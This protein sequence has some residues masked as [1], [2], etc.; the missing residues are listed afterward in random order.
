M[1]WP[2]IAAGMVLGLIALGYLAL[3]SRNAHIWIGAYAVQ[4]LKRVPPE[5][6]KPVHLY[7]CLMDHFEPFTGGASRSKALERTKRWCEEFPR[8]A[9]GF[10]DFHGRHPKHVL[11]YPQE[12]YDSEIIEMLSEVTR[13]GFFDV[14]IHMHHDGD[15]SE[16]LKRKLSDFRDK[17]YY[18]H[19]LLR[20]NPAEERIVYGFIHGNWALDNSRKDGRW[21]GVNNE[22]TIL[23]ETGCYADFTLPSSPSETQTKKINSIYYAIDDPGKPKSHNTGKDLRAGGDR[24]DHL[25]I[26]QGPLALNWKRRKFLFLPGIENGEIALGNDVTSDRIKL[27]IEN[28]P[29]LIGASNTKFVKVHTH[30]CQDSN[31]SYLLEGCLDRLYRLLC[32]EFNDGEKYV[33]HFVTAYEMYQKIIELSGY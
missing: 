23:K 20:L 32:K 30:G 12:A 7:F 21:C 2:T 22:I 28:S 14:E 10:V 27:W 1:E 25:I 8:L 3:R 31:L 17:L 24:Q 5:L 26:I 11:F 33:L 13:I 6:G 15:S 19:N 18:N 9:S 29:F 4:K 16:D